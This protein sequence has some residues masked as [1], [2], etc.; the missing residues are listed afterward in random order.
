LV[1]SKF[2]QAFFLSRFD[3]GMVKQTCPAS[4]LVLKQKR[5]KRRKEKNHQH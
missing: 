2:R 3:S 4:T 1:A 5:R